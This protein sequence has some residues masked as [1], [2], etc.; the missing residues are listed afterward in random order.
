[1]KKR[2]K[3]LVLF[4]SILLYSFF[5]FSSTANAVSGCCSH[6]GGVC[7]ACG[8]QANGKVICNDGWLGSSCYYSEMVKCQGYSPPA[9]STPTPHI[10]ATPTPTLSPT[11]VSIPTPTP[12]LTATPSP[13]P[14]PT[15]SPTP[16]PESTETPRLSPKPT[17]AGAATKVPTPKPSPFP[18]SKPSSAGKGTVGLSPLLIFLA[19]Q[20]G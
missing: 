20:H 15:A 17:I 14:T 8:P 16:T 18:S 10:L 7:C 13:S 2:I 12:N 4:T 3:L 1:M 9:T 11:P 6:Y 5:Y 19:Y